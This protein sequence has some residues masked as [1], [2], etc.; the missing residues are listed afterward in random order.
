MSFL[1]TPVFPDEVAAWAIGGRGFLTSVVE[2][3]GGNEY[4]NAAWSQSRGQW[5]WLTSD[6]QRQTNPSAAYA[7]KTLR[8]FFMVARGQLNTFRFRD[9]KDYTDDGAGVFVGLT[10]TTFQMYKNYTVGSVT[11]S[12]IIQ[13][14]RSAT[15]VV[16]GGVTPVVDYTT[17][18]VAVASGTPASW[19]G[20]FDI[21]CRFAVDDPKAGLSSDGT[22]INWQQLRLIEVRNP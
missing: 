5:E 14:P 15:V 21:P 1:E 22:F 19:T 13:K 2:T 11:Y 7:F 10:S 6:A 9:W 3:Y 8:N 20:Q 16:T 17:G 4:R 12:Q 18:I